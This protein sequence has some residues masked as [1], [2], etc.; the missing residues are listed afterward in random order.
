MKADVGTTT[1]SG[2]NT[3]AATAL[4]RCV[5]WCP[6][7]PSAPREQPAKLPRE[8]R[9]LLAPRASSVECH[10]EPLDALASMV[11]HERGF[12]SGAHK[13]P[14]LLILVEP[15]RLVGIDALVAAMSKY[16]HRAAVWQYDPAS[17]KRLARYTAPI[18]PPESNGHSHSNGNGNG[19]AATPAPRPRTIAAT[20]P[21][22]VSWVGMPGPMPT[23]QNTQ[24]PAPRLRLAGEAT[25]P[26]E[27]PVKPLPTAT[28]SGL[29]SVAPTPSNAPPAAKPSLTD[30]EVAM[31]LGD[32]PRGPNGVKP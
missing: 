7:D 27:A 3:N 25:T 29:P 10:A 12:V 5:V 24:R 6:R 31:L 20:P 18:A 15:S 11:L 21:A 16:A 32:A 14:M 30:E 26:A 23:P 4:A 1:S 8:L 9:E 17:P 2:P 22:F 28:V 13:D 19:N